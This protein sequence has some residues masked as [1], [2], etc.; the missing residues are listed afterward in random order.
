MLVN[1]FTDDGGI[2]QGVKSLKHKTWIQ[3]KFTI[4]QILYEENP[5]SNPP[6]CHL[7]KQLNYQKTKK[8]QPNKLIKTGITG[9]KSSLLRY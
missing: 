6:T 2:E 1:A 3:K 7:S 9:S 8:N 5:G 4:I